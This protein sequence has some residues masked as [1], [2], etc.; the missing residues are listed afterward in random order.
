M[1]RLSSFENLIEID[2]IMKEFK[3]IKWK[4]LLTN[5]SEK[6]SFRK[7][8]SAVHDYLED[9][10]YYDLDLLNENSGALARKVEINKSD[11]VKEGKVKRKES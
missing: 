11:T 9:S 7:L 10:H 4:F 1:R 5:R 6:S 8:N 2:Q 3:N